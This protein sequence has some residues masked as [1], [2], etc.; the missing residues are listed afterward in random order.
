MNEVCISRQ[1]DTDRQPDL[2]QPDASQTCQS[3]KKVEEANDR[4]KQSSMNAYGCFLSKLAASWC[5]AHP[6]TVDA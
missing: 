2:S 5:R 1:S 3:L 4:H 6:C